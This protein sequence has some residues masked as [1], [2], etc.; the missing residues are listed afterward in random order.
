M[1]LELLRMPSGDL[2]RVS[3][4]HQ[5]LQKGFVRVMVYKQVFHTVLVDF[6][7]KKFKKKDFQVKSFTYFLF[8]SISSE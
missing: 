8:S 2:G 4:A 6:Q 5:P 1:G 3:E 7:F